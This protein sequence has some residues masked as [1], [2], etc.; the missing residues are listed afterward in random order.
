[1]LGHLERVLEQFAA[2]PGARLADVALTGAQERTRV[3]EEWNRTER[4]FPRGATLHERFQAQVARRPDAAALAW[5]D[6]HL[7]YAELDA[8]ANRLAHHLRALGVGPDARVGVLLERGAELIVGI[9]AVLKAGG[10]YV[11]LDPG[12]PPERLR[13]MMADCGAGVLVTLERFAAGEVADGVRV[14]RLDGDADAIAARP[15]TP[16]RSGATPENLAYVVYTSGSTG[17]PKG[18]M[19]TH[20]NVVQLVVG[21]DYV[22]LR[23]GDRVAQAS[24]ASFDALAFEAW[25]ALLNGATLVGIPR[26]VLLSAPALRTLLREQAITTLYQTTALLNQLSRE[27]PDIFAPLRDV[28]FGGQAA[29]ADRVRA[30]LRSGRPARLLHMYGPTET[31]AW[32]SWHQVERVDDDAPTVSVGRPTGNQRIYLLDVALQPA[33]PGVPG[34]A[35]VGGA[36]VVR[37]YLGRPGLTA[38]RFV[39]DP[40]AA[41]PGARMYRTGDRLRWT[42]EGTLEFMGRLDAQVK[43]RGFRIE[44]GEIESVLCAQA[45]VGEARVVV[46]EDAPG[47]K[48]LVAYVVGA[49]EPEALRAHL[50]QVLPEYMVPS[51]VVCVKALPVTPNG[52][53]DERALPAPE[54][55]S[56][57][58]YVAPRTE[59]EASLAAIWAAVLGVERVGARDHFFE[60]GGHSLLAMRV[61]TRI[62]EAWGVEL[63]LRA[64]FDGPTLGALADA[65]EALRRAARP[66]LPPVEP[67]D[68]SE[69]L[70]LSFAQERLWFL[71]RL[72]PGGTG[73]AI[74]A[75]LRLRG[76]LDAAAL[77]RALGEVVRRHEALRTT[78]AERDGVPVQ[79]VHPF[80]GFAVP[81]EALPGRDAAER[82]AAA[83]RRCTEESVRPFDLAA[84]PL[85][86]AVLLR[87]DARD[88][89]LWMGMHHI[90][91]DGWSMDVLHRELSAL[92]AAF[93]AGGQAALP[94]LP[95]QYA[96]FAVW[97]RRELRGE[98]LERQMAYW[99]ERLAGAPQLLELPTDHPRPAVRSAR[100]GTVPVALPSPL[101]R[102]LQALAQAGDATLFMVLLAAFQLLLSKYSGSEDVVV[103]SPVAGR[104]RAETEG[105][106]GFFVNT[107]VLR[108]DLGGDPDFRETLRRVRQVT[109]GA[110]EHP[111]LPFERLVAE[112]QP[113][114]SL[115][116]SP[117]FQVVLSMD[118]PDGTVTRLPG[119]E[120]EGVREASVPAK[121]DLTLALAPSPRGLLGELSYSADLWEHATAERMVRHLERVLEQVADHPDRRASALELMDA[122]ERARVVE[123]WN[124][125][126]APYPADR[127]IH[128]LVQ[129]QAARTP[130]AVAAI[131]DHDR[132]TYG[133]LNARA[134]RLAH[135]LR[136]VGV[137]PEVRVGICL[138]RGLDLLAAL[139]AVL[140]AGGAYVPLDPA[141]PAERLENTLADAGAPV[142]VTQ[143][144]LRGLLPARPGVH[145]VVLED[146]RAAIDAASAADPESGVE[147][148]N[149]AYLIYTSGSTGRPK[150]VA[151][152]HGSAVAMLAWAWATYSAEELGGML[153]STSI[154][155]DMSVF[156]LFAPLAVG[157]R[158]IIVENALAL[159]AAP[160][161]DQVRL[162]DTVPSA[163]A[164]L[165]R[166][167]GIPAGVRT[168][169]LGGEPLPAALVDALYAGGVERVYDLYGPSED[170]T[171][172]TVA[173]RRP[174]GPVT[175]GRIL[176]NSRAYVLDAGL[177]PVPVGVPGELYLG[178]RGVTRGYLGRPSLTAGRYVPDPLGGEPGARM[179][180]TGDRVRWNADGTLQYLGRLDHQAKIRG[181]R[182]EP[183]EVE[184]ALARCPGVRDACVVV[185][186]DAPGDRR[187]VA[188][189]VGDADAGALRAALRAV[190][191]EYMVPAAFV[192]LDALPLMP[193]GKV[194]RRAL[195]RPEADGGAE[196][197]APRN[198]LEEAVAAICA[199]LLGVERVG[200]RDGFFE[201]GG[202]SLLV[203]RLIA[204][205]RDDFG[206]E[207]TI[208]A[209]FAAP[210]VEGIAAEVER[211]VHEELLALSDEELRAL[212]A[213]VPGEGR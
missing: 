1:M 117:L 80:A 72:E 3:V 49:A 127:C 145:T 147:P 28:L 6:L 60:R 148:G 82:E 45:G 95:V 47:E 69:P 110:Y 133:A 134:N 180:R 108:T 119:L 7:T 83:L 213:A 88:H 131:H 149:L 120:V 23:P 139:L 79:V 197:V 58:E 191:P 176:P 74:P 187:L 27:Q 200:M 169:N 25:G 43:I 84:G 77:E 156:E 71:D 18:V 12:Y 205:V 20:R 39:P 46:R 203:M 116:H 53:L 170:T 114:R 195:P 40:F 159:P 21:T 157:G 204:R 165:A 201:L 163:A 211:L 90:V 123:E 35:Y 55:I 89:V 183:G 132:L 24:N 152:Q 124:R 14:V 130:D 212:H 98:T 118:L 158:V 26:D 61:A 185:R 121:F 68:R 171:F 141:Y 206:V 103:G 160:A 135:H 193:N 128:Q 122:A 113:E 210:T 175:I 181:F 138:H 38:E 66:S 5:D 56:A 172:S 153:A 8:R 16:P 19:V 44:P 137:G 63:P 33:P 194:N 93:R 9:L 125:T 188:Y 10:C 190:L 15:A 42:A 36:G 105:L 155:F 151:I 96:D 196:Y 87:L 34:E 192:P 86:R 2:R 59:V 136:G 22:D 62:R 65:V 184:A 48:R 146:D 91:S 50:R 37:G 51:A 189:V 52:K 199:E 13:T 29:D 104:T 75:A 202:H 209:L 81:V 112:L 17:R 198:E 129:A 99:T 11:P 166:T 164:A 186:E 30:L 4:P 143:A 67:A 109:L 94:A 41:E 107:L 115:G 102:R 92:Y 64:L 168:V 101:L 106:I 178:G 100:G 150:G 207:L 73:Y 31:T 154:T 32:C 177:R 111:D 57:A 174:G 76:D 97:Q 70:P 142:I 179:Y 162:L 182:V 54:G 140:K 126:A 144:A 167:G 208:R 78:F 173:L 161:A 85:F